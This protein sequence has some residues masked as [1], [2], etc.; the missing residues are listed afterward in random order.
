MLRMISHGRRILLACSCV[1]TGFA[2]WLVGGG[3]QPA[4]GTDLAIRS[5]DSLDFSSLLPARPAEERLPLSV[6]REGENLAPEEQERLLEEQINVAVERAVA[7]RPAGIPRPVYVPATDVLP[8]KGLV[9]HATRSAN[10]S[11]PFARALDGFIQARW[12]ELARDVT[13]WTDSAGVTRPVRNE[14]EFNI[15][16]FLISLSGSVGGEQV[17]YI[18]FRCTGRP[19]RS[20]LSRLYRLA[21][22]DGG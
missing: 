7:E 16:R 13:E 1:A 6:P 10:S 19:T 22:S 21:S 20:S 9:P 5:L 11:F 17:A 14:N 3:L 12:L 18:T 8:P 4:W 2:G 15:N